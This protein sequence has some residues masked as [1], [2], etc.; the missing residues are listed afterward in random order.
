MGCGSSKKL[1]PINTTTEKPMAKSMSGNVNIPALEL[2]ES[3]IY[4]ISRA[5][6]S[7][8]EED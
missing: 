2:Y 5:C 4:T 6:A 7:S 8:D 1:H 3:T